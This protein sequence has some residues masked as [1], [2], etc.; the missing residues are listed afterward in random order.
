MAN[1]RLFIGLIS[2]TSAD[3][4]DAALVAVSDDQIETSHTLEVAFPAALKTELDGALNAPDALTAQSLGR[5]DSALGDAFGAAALAL[6]DASG[7]PLPP[8]LYQ[9]SS[10]SWQGAPRLEDR[11]LCLLQKTALSAPPRR[12]LGGRPG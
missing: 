9:L 11:A 7:Q 3:A 1:A 2:G 4:I 12:H 5:L 8:G 10:E 6:L